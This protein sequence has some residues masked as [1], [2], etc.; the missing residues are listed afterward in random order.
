MLYAY[1]RERIVPHVSGQGDTF[2][3][4]RALK[5]RNDGPRQNDSTP[6]LPLTIIRCIF[7]STKGE[8]RCQEASVHQRSRA[9]ANVTINIYPIGFV[10]SISAKCVPTWNRQHRTVYTDTVYLDPGTSE[11]YFFFSS[12]P[13]PSVDGARDQST[14]L[15]APYLVASHSF[16]FLK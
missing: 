13:S 10:P 14:S 11:V 5:R 6:K 16:A 3:A 7:G 2:Q 15:P 12:L 9:G 1:S 4:R 8:T